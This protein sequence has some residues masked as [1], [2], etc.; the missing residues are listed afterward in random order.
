MPSE[1]DTLGIRELAEFT[2]L[3][4]HTLRWY[5]R[6]GLLSGVGRTADGRRR[7]GPAAVRAVRLVQALRRTGM[8]V[9]E[10]RTFVSFGPGTPA[11]TRRRI[12]VLRRQERELHRRLAELHGDLEVLRAKID[13]YHDIIASGRDC[14][15]DVLTDFP[16]ARGL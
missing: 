12:E 8:P 14:E 4:A 6:E 9:A 3:T 2:G 15:S 16:H 7:Y 10:I 1:T 5:E 13:D 11:N